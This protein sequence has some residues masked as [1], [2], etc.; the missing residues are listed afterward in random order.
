MG[1]EFK[2]IASGT[3]TSAQGFLAGA[4]SSG[5]KPPAELDLG[6]LYSREPCVA[7]GVFTTNAVR[8]AP[9]VLSQR[10]LQDRN[11]Q[12]VVVN[13]GCANACT[14][15]AGMADAEGMAG[16]AAEK[17]G[18]APQDVLVASTGVIGIALPMDRVRVGIREIS[19]TEGGGHELARAMMTTDTFAKEIA[20]FVEAKPNGFTIGGVAKGSGMIHPNMATMLSFLATDAAVDANFLQSALQRA[21]DSSFNMVTIDGDTSPSDMVMLLA[22]GL[23]R[24]ETINDSNGGVF[25]MAL[26]EICLHLAKCIARD[27]EGATKLLEVAVEGALTEAEARLAARTVAGS[28]LVKA[29]M[30]GNDPNWGRIVAAL[31]RSGAGVTETKLDVYLNDVCVM[32][33]GRP[34]PFDKQEVG[35]KLAGKEVLLRLNLNLGSGGATAWGCDLSEE[36]A[37]INSA[38]TT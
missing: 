30:H 15:D 7:A 10:H 12:A 17:L 36:Y 9:V 38:Y 27:G 21:V 2:T 35:T 22:N 4:I 3:V 6:I 5:I 14:A 37:T 16:V 31:G 32:K 11:A 28:S 33:Q 1:Y 29:A 20:V 19:I 23:A 26:H 25:Q 34:V 13:S 24:N 8:A 18:L